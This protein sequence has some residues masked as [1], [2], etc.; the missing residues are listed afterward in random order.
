MF[1]GLGF[2]L[3]GLFFWLLG[4]GWVLGVG[5]FWGLVAGLGLGVGTWA[6]LVVLGFGRVFWFVLGAPFWVG[7]RARVWRRWWA[8]PRLK[9]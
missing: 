3:L 2:W 1:L 5:L 7:F 4:L 9:T 6:A 8:G